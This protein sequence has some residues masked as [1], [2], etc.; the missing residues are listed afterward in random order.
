MGPFPGRSQCGVPRCERLRQ[1]RLLAFRCALGLLLTALAS[2]GPVRAL[3]P[4]KSFHQYVYTD[5]QTTDGLPQNTVR[6]IAQTPDG[7][8]W[9]ATPAGLVRF[10]GIQFTTFNRKNTPALPENSITAL[11]TDHDGALWI[12]TADGGLVRLRNGVFTGYTKAN[13]LSGNSISTLYVSSDGTLWVGT[14]DGGLNR[15]HDGKFTHYTTRDGLS[16][17]D[18]AS[19]LE[20][21]AGGLW[22]GTNSNFL[23]LFKDGHF[24]RYRSPQGPADDD[25]MCLYQDPDGTLWIGTDGGGVD[26][27]K[28]GHFTTWS[29]KRGLLSRDVFAIHRDRDGNLWLGTMQGGLARF[30]NGKIVSYT[31]T[32]D[33]LSS[34]YIDA[35][36][37][38]RDGNL[39]LGT[40]GGGL[41][42]L[43]DG[44]VTAFTKADGLSGNSIKCV[45]Q[46]HDGTIWIGTEGAWITE[47][48][49]GKFAVLGRGLTT[50]QSFVSV[51]EDA[52]GV[53]WWATYDREPYRLVAGKLI[54]FRER[55]EGVDLEAILCLHDGRVLAG[56]AD[57]SIYEFRGRQLL[58]LAKGGGRIYCMLQDRDGSVWAGTD[59]AGL[60][61]LSGHKQTVL[62]TAYG[63]PS[64]SV[65]A[66]YQDRSG[67][68][69]IGTEDGLCRLKNGKLTTYTTEDGLFNDSVHSILEDN[70]GFLWMSG[71][72][73]ISRVRKRDVEQFAAGKIRLFHSDSFGID[74]G[75]ATSDCEGDGLPAAWKARDGR[76]WFA[77]SKGV[78]V[79]D[80]AHLR[81]HSTT[82]P[83]VIEQVV[84]DGKAVNPQGEISLP[85]GV[86]RIEI[87]YTAPSLTSPERVS[88]RYRLEGYDPQ[89]IEAG[90]RRVAYFTGLPPGRYLFWVTASNGSGSW[91]APTAIVAFHQ[92]PHLYQ[93]GLFRA[94][95]IL[96]LATLAVAVYR[97]LLQSH[98]AREQKL[99]R[100]VEQRTGELRQAKLRA[101]AARNEHQRLATAI[102][103]AAEA[104]MMTDVEG[105]IL[106]VN[107]AFSRM[108]GYGRDEVLGANPRLLKSGK[109][110]LEFYEGLWKTIR[111]G[112][113]WHSELINR[114]K[115]GSVYDE[116]M[117]ITPVRDGNGTIS[118]FIALKQDITPRKQSEAQL[119]KAREVAEAASRAKSEFLA[120]M[121]HEI[122]TPMNGVLGMTELA[123]DTELTPEQRDYLGMVKT[124]ADALLTVINDIL[125]FSKIEAGKLEL[126]RIPFKL[127]ESVYQSIK[128]LVMRA[129]QKGL[130]LTVEVRPDVPDEIVADPTRLRQVIINLVGNAIK[131]TEQ[132]EIGLE[133][134]RDTCNEDNDSIQLHFTVR[135][136]GIG[137]ESG[138]QKLI[139]EPFSQADGTTA[140]KFGGTGLGLTI[141][142]RLV[143]IMGGRIWVESELGKGS[144]FHFTMRAEAGTAGPLAIELQPKELEGL[145]VLV[146]D[147]NSANRRILGETLH[148]WGMTATSAADAREALI[149]LKETYRAGAGFSLLL[150]DVHMPEIDGFELVERIDAELGLS[151]RNVIMLTSAGQRGDAA[152]CRAL[153]VAAYLTKPVDQSQLQDAIL[154]VLADNRATSHSA[155]LVTR[156]TL[157]EGR[158]RLRILLAEDNLVNQRLALRFLERHGHQVVVAGNGHEVLAAVDKQA[159]DAILMDVQM[160]G[161]DGFEATAAIREREKGTSSHVAIIA[162]T[163]HA[164]KGDEERC[165]AA[166]MD[167]YISK[168]IRSEQL[169]HALDA[170]C[171][172]TPVPAQTR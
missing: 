148:R 169:F 86:K 144:K 1:N 111:T 43:K 46:S 165:R 160:P 39:W 116:E 50:L 88:F 103:Q 22:V 98:Q 13:G 143:E 60:L 77:T 31:S 112:N 73:G 52:T 95:L 127:R 171:P 30:K 90:P 93:T 89:W 87:Y 135:D 32:K 131:F 110:G 128:P 63:L 28:D 106:Y 27:L 18:I 91:S 158:Q 81:M 53:L 125:D 19:I 156:H 84:V 11:C 10:G 134:A 146:V 67:A 66:L 59:H 105:D 6:A 69:W 15:F 57:G 108:T 24:T 102:E 151:R 149:A 139:F 147:D 140:R 114:R 117:T 76:L 126:D 42:R 44:Q 3:N 122:R 23:N 141:S 71:P 26:Q 157:R 100:L 78:S 17:N 74:D 162:M 167:G 8:L 168:P 152:R 12:G 21:R 94:V 123:L 130:E 96:C 104:V 55:Q 47:L 145:S 33:G 68:L 153:G 36:Y 172:E 34:D 170:A 58:R 62:S 137:I 25:A 161:M 82:Y 80:P 119:Q 40:Q 83:A 138:K 166:G 70:Y 5:W 92:L 159:F 121:S 45:Y 75:M 97:L 9:L 129:D 2:A 136:T 107:P 38:D 72:G 20:N 124:S 85:P 118:G 4:A 164:M 7:F 154:T 37:E 41:V 16:G 155:R 54:P 64:S 163:A 133:V 61:H 101:E 79:I 109:Q 113:V 99:E 35:I 132:G 49:N 150:I 142:A 120:N 65:R 51:S 48:K 115:D 14:H 56:D 29:L